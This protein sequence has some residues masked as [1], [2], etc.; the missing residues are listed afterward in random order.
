MR[1]EP[2]TWKPIARFD[3]PAEGFQVRCPPM[4]YFPAVRQVSREEL[5]A[6]SWMLSVSNRSESKLRMLRAPPLGM[7]ARAERYTRAAGTGPT[8]G[9]PESGTQYGSLTS[10]H[11]PQLDLRVDGRDAEQQ[12]GN[13]EASTGLRCLAAML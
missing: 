7:P 8:A 1:I 3:P 12:T 9:T 2:F 13:T 5:V 6:T 11:L 4:R 10:R